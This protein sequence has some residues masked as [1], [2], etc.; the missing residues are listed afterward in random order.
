MDMKR[1][2]KTIMHTEGINLLAAQRVVNDMV[3]E[4]VDQIRNEYKSGELR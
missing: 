3:S 2:L 4:A 1:L